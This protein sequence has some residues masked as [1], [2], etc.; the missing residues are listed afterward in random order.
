MVVDIGTGDGRAV[1]LR[2]TAEP[3]SLVIGVD[4]A[5]AVMAD[6]S[7]RG[8]RRHIP[9][10]LFLAAGAEAL[11]RSPLV[12]RADH[13]TVTMPWGSLLRGVLGLACDAPALN[14]VAS[15]LRPDDVIDVLVS[16]TPADQVD[17]LANLTAEHEPAIAAAWSAAGLELTSMCPT[18]LAEVAATG[19][20]WARRLGDARPVWRLT[21]QR[22]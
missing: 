10:A 11:A 14:G 12:G 9:N 16:V 8:D 15:V 17:G 2:A 22:R 19:S 7:R 3:R 20:S 13:V 6:A 21:G 4:A 5:A 18:T 1:L